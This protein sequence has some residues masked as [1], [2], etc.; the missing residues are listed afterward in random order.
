MRAGRDKLWARVGHERKIDDLL[1]E[2][3]NGG[4][5]DGDGQRR[6]RERGRRKWIVMNQQVK[7][8]TLNRH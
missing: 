8:C 5:G 7:L 3:R 1:I 6:W 2:K 4:R